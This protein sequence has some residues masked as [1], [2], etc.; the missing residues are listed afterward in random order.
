MDSN[1]G[2]CSCGA[3]KRSQNEL[4]RLNAILSLDAIEILVSRI[5]E[6]EQL[7]EH[8][9]SLI[10]EYQSLI[11]EYQGLIAEYMVAK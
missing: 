2:P 7:A 4:D 6:L 10:T 8:Y 9:Q 1:F 5:R 11:A 3:E